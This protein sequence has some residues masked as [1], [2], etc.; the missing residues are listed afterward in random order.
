MNKYLKHYYVHYVTDSHIRV[1][2]F[3]RADKLEMFVSLS[4]SLIFLG[5]GRFV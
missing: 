2:F 5:G 4:L 1:K 3:P